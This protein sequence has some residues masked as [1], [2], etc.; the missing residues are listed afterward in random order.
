[1][2]KQVKQFH[3]LVIQNPTLVARLKQA[4]DRASFVAIAVQLGTECGYSFTAREVESYVNQ[5][6]LVLMRQFS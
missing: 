2:S 6:M 3:Q 5:N 1:M 4:S